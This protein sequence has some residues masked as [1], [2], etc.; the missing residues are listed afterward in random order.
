MQPGISELINNVERA[1]EKHIMENAHL[2]DRFAC[3][4]D[5]GCFAA[6]QEVHKVCDDLRVLAGLKKP[7]ERQ[8]E[9]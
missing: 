9:D 5:D 4:E 1:L 7:V 6:R 3:A 8:N 2:R